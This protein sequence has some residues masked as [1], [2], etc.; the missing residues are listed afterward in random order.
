MDANDILSSKTNE[1]RTPME[2]TSIKR[3]LKKKHEDSDFDISTGNP[4][5]QTKHSSPLTIDAPGQISKQTKLSFPIGG[6]TKG[7]LLKLLSTTKKSKATLIPSPEQSTVISFSTSTL[8]KVPKG[9][10]FPQISGS[11]SVRNPIQINAKGALPAPQRKKQPL[12]THRVALFKP[13]EE[14]DQDQHRSLWEKLR[15]IFQTR[16]S[17]FL[18]VGKKTEESKAIDFP[19]KLNEDREN[20]LTNLQHIPKDV[21]FTTLLNHLIFA[22]GY[23]SIPMVLE[24]IHMLGDFSR[25]Y[26]DFLNAIVCYNQLRIAADVLSDPK[27]KLVALIKLGQIVKH[28]KMYEDSL[29]FFKKALEYAWFNKQT[30]EELKIYDLMGQVYYYMG[31]IKRSEYY[32]ERSLGLIEG[33]QSPIK[34]LSSKELEFYMKYYWHDLSSV[35]TLLLAKLN[36]PL[37]LMTAFTTSTSDQSLLQNLYQEAISAL[38]EH[39]ERSIKVGVH[40][41]EC[42]TAKNEEED[43]YLLKRII[44]NRLSQILKDNEF[45]TEIR[46][47]RAPK[48]FT[49][50]NMS[51]TNDFKSTMGLDFPTMHNSNEFTLYHSKNK[52]V[53][54]NQTTRN[55][56]L[57][58][59]EARK[60]VKSNSILQ[61]ERR[62]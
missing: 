26:S 2:H 14:G 62:K 18:E 53:S 19:T 57:I 15:G 55:Q 59:F 27:I 35:N 12:T 29:H 37:T 9:G 22:C 54:L 5:P 61:S 8:T 11:L 17:P 45:E 52:S 36:L 58:L 13:I 32:H 42:Y 38:N 46:S 6:N 40:L 25:D 16:S 60:Q 50:V 34:D 44:K 43:H 21:I 39:N 28:L 33:E 4:S 24:A 10:K 23:K 3:F 30:E 1:K 31:D 41:F 49:A 48:Q 7:D 56:K 47:P 20:L 51:P